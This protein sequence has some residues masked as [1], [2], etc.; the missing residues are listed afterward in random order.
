MPVE[1]KLTQYIFDKMGVPT[2]RK[3]LD[4]SAYR[5]KLVSGNVANASTPGYRAKDIDFEQEFQSATGKTNHL[6]GVTTQSGHIPLGSHPQKAP[7][8]AQDKVQE[9]EMNSVDID[10]EVSNM[11][12]NELLYTIGA[13]LLQRRF[14]GL[15]TAITSK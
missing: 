10:R 12:Q 11:T 14:E 8:V 9:G 2:F 4:L 6:E 3:Y 5:H 15:R 13:K 1:N 7:K